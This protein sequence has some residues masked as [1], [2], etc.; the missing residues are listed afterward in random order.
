MEPRVP[1]NLLPDPLDQ[2]PTLDLS[3][4]KSLNTDNDTFRKK[5]GIE[6]YKLIGG[7]KCKELLRCAYCGFPF[8][9][10]MNW[11]MM[12]V[13]HV[14]PKVAASKLKINRDIWDSILNLVFCCRICN[15]FNRGLKEEAKALEILPYQ[16]KEGA[17][18]EEFL[19]LRQ[20]TFP[21][22]LEDI[23]N[24]RVEAQQIYLTLWSPE[25]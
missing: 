10:F 1:L 8:D 23:A 11:L 22:R 15:D 7:P 21:R 9:N 5:Y 18:P 17:S 12:S 25:I 20:A 14:V 4:L 13:D 2:Y 3:S 19:R 6:M 16:P 24:K